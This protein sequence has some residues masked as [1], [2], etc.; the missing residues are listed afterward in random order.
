MKI[1]KRKSNNNHDLLCKTVWTA[2]PYEE[3][4]TTGA[5]GITEV[6]LGA[7]GIQLFNWQE[8]L[9]KMLVIK[10][11]LTH[12]LT[13]R[14]EDK[15]K[16]LSPRKT[17]MHLAHS[18]TEVARLQEPPHFSPPAHTS[19]FECQLVKLPFFKWFLLAEY[20]L[21]EWLAEVWSN[22]L[23][24]KVQKSQTLLIY[25]PLAYHHLRQKPKQT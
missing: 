2:W 9:I 24:Y 19:Y 7:G 17:H 20:S 4:S 5:E 13:W 15:H 1:L 11:S 6:V 21:G 25:F 16:V 18:S 23:S 10:T 14:T 3:L 12:Q 8:Q 22:P